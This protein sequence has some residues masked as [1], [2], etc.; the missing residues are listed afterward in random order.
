MSDHDFDNYE[1][2]I[3]TTSDQTMVIDFAISILH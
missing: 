1:V 3:Q 2:Q